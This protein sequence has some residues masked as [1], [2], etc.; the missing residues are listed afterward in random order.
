MKCTIGEK[1]VELDFEGTAAELLA[2][3]N[4]NRETAIVKA[5][6]RIVPETELLASA[7][8]VEILRFR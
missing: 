7:D 5:N 3:L 8:I 6:G 2:K 1:K 4:I